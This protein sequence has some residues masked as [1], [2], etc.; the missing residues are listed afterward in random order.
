MRVHDRL[1][2]LG[3]PLPASPAMP[4]TTSFSWV[5]VLGNRVLVSGHGAQ[6]P[7]G[8]PAGPFGRVPDAVSLEQAQ[9]SARLAALAV[10]ASV[11]QAVGDLDR[12]DAWLTVTG[13]VQAE[14][15]YPKTTAVLNSFSE[16]VL[17]VFGP[18]IGQHARTAI[19]AAALPLDLPVIVAAEL[20]L[21]DR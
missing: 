16:V 17:D 15:G 13:F 14:A 11:E 2:D 7:D 6:Q 3:L 4:V 18:S 10:I 21:A 20:H 12:I 19:G 8:A 9:Q 1:R 5:R